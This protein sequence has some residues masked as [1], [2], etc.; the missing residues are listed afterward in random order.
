MDFYERLR[1]MDAKEHQALVQGLSRIGNPQEIFAHIAAMPV[2]CEE[3]K[4]WLNNLSEVR[5]DQRFLVIC[6]RNTITIFRTESIKHF[7]VSY[8]TCLKRYD[9]CVSKT[10]FHVETQ[11]ARRLFDRLMQLCPGFSQTP[12]DRTPM[13]TRDF[14]IDSRGVT[15][16]NYS[17][18]GKLKTT[19]TIPLH[20]IR[21][22][23]Q[24][25]DYDAEDSGCNYLHLRLQDGSVRKITPP[26]GDWG[27]W[28]GYKIALKLKGFLPRLTYEFPERKV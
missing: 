13:Q 8:G 28:G 23:F 26:P 27:C 15:I 7:Y 19:E 6:L 5:I 25:N 12:P 14:I 9:F 22:C 21:S 3:G 16:L 11:Y 17:L 24:T 4:G 18:F 2:C 10:E 1:K 20:S